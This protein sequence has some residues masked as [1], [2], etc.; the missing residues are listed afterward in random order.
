MVELHALLCVKTD[1]RVTLMYWR[2]YLLLLCMYACVHGCKTRVCLHTCT[3]GRARTLAHTRTINP[4]QIS[5]ESIKYNLLYGRPDA[6]DAE[7]EA[8]AKAA[9]VYDTIM[10]FPEKFET[11][12]GERGLRLSGG[13]KQRV[14]IA[15]FLI[16]RLHVPLCSQVK[17][18][19]PCVNPWAC[20]SG[21]A[22]CRAVIAYL[23]GS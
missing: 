22:P 14:A 17:A 7:M 2:V 11:R 20:S 8:A 21:R 4:K 9:A 18:Y 15:R 12:V 1:A 13:E 19:G 23:C 10:K 3:R 16:L 6:S 5:A